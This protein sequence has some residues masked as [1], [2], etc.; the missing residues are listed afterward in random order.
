MWLRVKSGHTTNR[1]P[2]AA[3]FFWDVQVTDHRLIKI[4]PLATSD[5]RP[6]APSS[7]RHALTPEVYSRCPNSPAGLSLLYSHPCGSR[8]DRLP[9]MTDIK[10]TCNIKLIP[11]PGEIADGMGRRLSALRG[12]VECIRH[13]LAGGLGR[14]GCGCAL[15]GAFRDRANRD[16]S[17]R[18]CLGRP[19]WSGSHGSS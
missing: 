18:Q 15:R 3:T 1:A 4:N 17:R 9:L 16:G 19:E 7:D 10:L 6:A 14:C 12:M 8:L 5:K 13:R 2:K 11:I